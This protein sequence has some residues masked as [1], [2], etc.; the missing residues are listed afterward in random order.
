MKMKRALSFLMAIAVAL[1][2]VACG[3]GSSSTTEGSSVVE[4]SATESSSA[5]SLEESSNKVEEGSNKS[6]SGEYD[7][8][9]YVDIYGIYA[10]D[11]NRA[12]FLQEKADEFAKQYE[13]E[14]GISVKIEYLYQGGYDDVDEKLTVGAV[15]GE[16]PVISQI[17]VTFLP[18]LYPLATDLSSYFE[19]DVIDNYVDGLMVTAYYN[20]TL[21]AIPGGR[22]YPVM[23]V[24]RE[25]VEQ[26][27]HTVD[28][29]KTWDDLHTVAADIAALGDDIEGY[30][31]YWDTDIWL[32]ESALYSNGGDITNADATEVLFNKDGAGAVYLQ[33][34]QD[35][36]AD[37]SAYSAYAQADDKA[38]TAYTEKFLNGELGIMFNSITTYGSLKNSMETEGYDVDVCVINQPAGLAG[39]SIVSGGNNFIICNTATETQKQ[40]AA[41]YLKY[42]SSDENQAEWNRV[43]GYLATTKSTYESEYFAENLEDPNLVQIADGVKYAHKRQQKH[44]REMYTYM[45]GYL[46]DFTINPENYDCNEL[47]N[48]MAVHCQEILDAG[49]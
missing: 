41:E 35:M 42:I 24:N 44:W 28:E 39:N 5:S 26:A 34:V 10:Q 36:L 48:E 30:G 25:L 1:P 29:I 23:Y 9:V 37:G 6:A 20:D 4:S 46:K 27:G 21:Y 17:A 19:Q 32:W 8:D 14:T 47:V 38:G 12:V 45:Y 31:V 33:L 43:S 22:S 13:E 40:V 18:E 16:M 11:N 15:S 2:L 49:E 7:T 3:S